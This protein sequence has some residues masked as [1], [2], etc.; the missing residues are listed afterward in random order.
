MNVT[1]R[2]PTCGRPENGP[3]WFH[4]SVCCATFFQVNGYAQHL[5]NGACLP[6]DPE[7]EEVMP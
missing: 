4:C 5:D 7:T 3:P 1:V 2:C 6:Y